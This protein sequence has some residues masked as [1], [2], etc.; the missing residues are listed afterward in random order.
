MSF[1]GEGSAP[2]RGGPLP[3]S[4]PARFR[5]ERF[6][7]A[8]PE[9]S[10]KAASFPLMAMHTVKGLVPS[11]PILLPFLTSKICAGP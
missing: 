7:M 3:P 11:T 1:T 4:V 10:V 9:L 2:R 6:Q 8:T 5:L